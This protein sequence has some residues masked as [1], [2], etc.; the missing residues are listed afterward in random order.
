MK[1]KVKTETSAGAFVVNDVAIHL[2]NPELPF[3]GVG[4]SGS[5][6]YHGK[7][8]F[9]ACSNPK[10][11][12]DA[13]IL[14]MYPV[15]LRFPPYKPQ[16]EV[17]YPSNLENTSVHDEQDESSHSP[18]HGK[19]DRDPRGDSAADHSRPQVPL[20]NVRD[21]KSIIDIVI[22]NLLYYEGC[23]TVCSAPSAGCSWLPT[24][25]AENRSGT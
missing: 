3:G 17:L 25:T 5:G 14:D 21:C 9:D 22:I 6:R 1:E 18:T 13:K 23:D 19:V 8:G 15:S 12:V 7:C 16:G 24:C 11:V 2:I 20:I 10:S 4:L